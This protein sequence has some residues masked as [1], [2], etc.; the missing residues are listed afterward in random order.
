MPCKLRLL[1][2]ALFTIRMSM[3][4]YKYNTSGNTASTDLFDGLYPSYSSPSNVDCIDFG[5]KL[6][7]DSWAVMTRLSSKSRRRASNASV[8]ISPHSL[9]TP[10]NKK[11]VR[12]NPS[13]QPTLSDYCISGLQPILLLSQYPE[14]TSNTEPRNC[15]GLTK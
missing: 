2:L 7:S 3:P 9:P 5:V 13:K 10:V 12:P 11:P 14:S 15:R 4:S 6:C 1:H 8:K